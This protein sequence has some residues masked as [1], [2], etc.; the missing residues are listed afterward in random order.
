MPATQWVFL[1]GCLV[2]VVVV[3]TLIS[4][5]QPASGFLVNWSGLGPHWSLFPLPG[6][7][8]W[9]HLWP[10]LWWPHLWIISYDDRTYDGPRLSLFPYLGEADDDDDKDDEGHDD[11]FLVVNMDDVLDIYMGHF[12][13][14][15]KIN[16]YFEYSNW[17][18]VT[19]RCNAVFKG[20]LQR[21]NGKT[22][23]IIMPEK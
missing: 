21:R 19:G 11:H 5:C 8:W 3:K 17:C 10:Y 22:N 18:V 14:E 15:T 23:T 20:N 4:R 6:W 2:F 12:D 7:G 9:P 1:L 16:S 13:I